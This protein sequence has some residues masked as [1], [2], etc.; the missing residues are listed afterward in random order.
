MASELIPINIVIGDRSYRI[1]T[2]PGD[3]SLSVPPLKPSMKKLLIS[4]PALP[5]KTCRII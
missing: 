3:E 4:A 1:K 5:E 2:T